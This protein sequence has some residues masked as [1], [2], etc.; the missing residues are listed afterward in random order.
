MRS[1]TGM[2]TIV[3]MLT[4]AITTVIGVVGADMNGKSGAPGSSVGN[5]KNAG[6]VMLTVDGIGARGPVM[7]T[8]AMAVVQFGS[9][10]NLP[11]SPAANGAAAMTRPNLAARLTG[12]EDIKRPRLLAENSLTCEWQDRARGR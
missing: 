12:P 8:L 4:H 11:N 3:G 2:E 9:T 10:S 6:T 1:V 7:P 5:G